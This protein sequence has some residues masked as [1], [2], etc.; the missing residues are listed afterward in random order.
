MAIVTRRLV[1]IIGRHVKEGPASETAAARA[2]A[3]AAAAAAFLLPFVPSLA[4]VGKTR[5]PKRNTGEKKRS[6]RRCFF[7]H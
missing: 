5:T 1:F 4:E 6:E 7:F 3:A 2:A